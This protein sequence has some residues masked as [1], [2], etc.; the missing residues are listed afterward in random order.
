MIGYTVVMVGYYVKKMATTC[1][2]VIRYLFDPF[3]ICSYIGEYYTI[4]VVL[5]SA[6]G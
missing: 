2:P 3:C 6:I 5:L 4:L 1:S